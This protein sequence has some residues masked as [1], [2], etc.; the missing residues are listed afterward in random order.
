MT[1]LRWGI[2]AGLLLSAGASARGANETELAGKAR[3]VF[4]QYCAR[5]HHGPG[6]EGGEFDVTRH[7]DL[8]DKEFWDPAL[9]VPGKPEASYLFQR[10]TA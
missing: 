1:M 7:P 3:G 2:V 10:V 8:L 5:C 6:S 9:V 4:R